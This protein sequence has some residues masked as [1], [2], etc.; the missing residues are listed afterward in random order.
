MGG[1]S[2]F[3]DE[4]GSGWITEPIPPFPFAAD[5][6]AVQMLNNTNGVAVGEI[7]VNT[8]RATILRRE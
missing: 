5:L 7:D 6:L 3:R 4:P 2:I 8:G 1:T